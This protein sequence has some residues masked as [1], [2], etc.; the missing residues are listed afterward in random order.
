MRH[1]LLLLCSLLLFTNAVPADEFTGYLAAEWGVELSTNIEEVTSSHITTDDVQTTEGSA[2]PAFLCVYMDVRDEEK[3]SFESYRRR[4]TIKPQTWRIPNVRNAIPETDNS[5][6]TGIAYASYTAVDA[7]EMVLLSD[8]ASC[9]LCAA[10]PMQQE[11]FTNSAVYMYANLCLA[12]AG[13]VVDAKNDAASKD[14]SESLAKASDDA[15]MNAGDVFGDALWLTAET[16]GDVMLNNGDV[17]G[18]AAGLLAEACVSTKLN[19][20]ATV[21]G[22][23]KISLNVE[24][25]QSL[26]A[27]AS[28]NDG[29]ELGRNS[30]PRTADTICNVA[31]V[32]RTPGGTPDQTRCGLRRA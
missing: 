3:S 15:T 31:A 8:M 4:A 16:D 7:P 14:A 13:E 28:T 29:G 26:E 17:F 9:T 19:D 24:P 2:C 21:A 10:S 23:T 27:A 22:T 11:W 1:F 6:F 30:T 20:G 32:H 5:N 12:G 25:S 18:K